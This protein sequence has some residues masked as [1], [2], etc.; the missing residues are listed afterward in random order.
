MLKFSCARG[1]MVGV[2]QFGGHKNVFACESSPGA[3]R[4][5]CRADLALGSGMSV[6]NPNAGMH[7][8]A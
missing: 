5:Q 8:D 2:P 6:P 3:T 1:A 4:L 7:P